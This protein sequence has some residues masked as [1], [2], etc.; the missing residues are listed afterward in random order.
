M[1]PPQRKIVKIVKCLFIHL[2]RPIVPPMV[3]LKI[4]F[5]LLF[6]LRHWHT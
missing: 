4:L 6:V 1:T 5:R 2:A 3:S